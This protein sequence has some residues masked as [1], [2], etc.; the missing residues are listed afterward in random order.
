MNHL[1][2]K[3]LGTVAFSMCVV[4][5]AAED[6]KKQPEPVKPDNS[7]VNE[8]DRALGSVTAD[9]QGQSKPDVEMTRAEPQRAAAH[10]NARVKLARRH[11]NPLDAQATDTR[12]QTWPCRTG[13]ICN[14]QR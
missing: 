4:A 9:Q 13:G 12:I 8:R 2:T 11:G 1:I 10:G 6:D 7:K 3:L 14:W 5:S